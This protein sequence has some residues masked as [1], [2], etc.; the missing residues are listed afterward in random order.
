LLGGIIASAPHTF[1]EQ[2]AAAA[3]PPEVD[4]PVLTSAIEEPLPKPADDVALN[5]PP[6]VESYAL[7]PAPSEGGKQVY[8]AAAAIS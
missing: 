3:P 7:P 1:G 8:G 6:P 4:P 5:G 2:S